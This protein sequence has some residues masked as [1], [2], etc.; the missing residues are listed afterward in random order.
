MLFHP[1]VNVATTGITEVGSFLSRLAERRGM[2]GRA[3]A[4]AAETGKPLVVVGSPSSGVL[5]GS[6]A[7]HKCGDLPCVDVAGCRVCGAPPADISEPGSI[8]TADGGCV[9]LVQYVLEYVDD[10]DGAWREI[11]RA[12][13][14]PRDIFVGYRSQTVISRLSTGAK[15]LIDSAPPNKDGRLLYH[16]VRRQPKVLVKGCGK[17]K[18]GTP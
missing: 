3:I 5:R 18:A 7:Q 2:Y 14:S 6:V 8:P 10:I 17:K 16:N 9:V 4:R 1:G 12:A 13:G 11:T 15:R